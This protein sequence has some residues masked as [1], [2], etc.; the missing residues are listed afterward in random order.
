[1]LRTPPRESE[2]FPR[3]EVSATDRPGISWGLEAVD[4][5]YA[6]MRA[7]RQAEFDSNQQNRGAGERFR[8]MPDAQ[9]RGVLEGA[10]SAKKRTP[11]RRQSPR[12]CVGLRPLQWA[13][14]GRWAANVQNG[15][16]LM[17]RA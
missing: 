5:T 9:L 4:I 16:T 17:Q 1:M 3:P 2:L 15:E 12:S 11:I 6:M 13:I 8:P 10:P 14:M 7:A